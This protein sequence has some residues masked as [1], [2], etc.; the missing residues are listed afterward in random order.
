MRRSAAIWIGIASTT[1]VTLGC[2]EPPLTLGPSENLGKSES[3]II[4]GYIDEGHPSVGLIQPSGCTA[5]LVGKRTALTAAHCI[6]SSGQRITFC[7]DGHCMDGTAYRHPGFTDDDLDD[8]DVA[9]VRLD[10]N[11]YAAFGTVP[12]RLS[13]SQPIEDS[14]VVPVGF[15]CTVWDT[16]TG[17]GTKR[18]GYAQIKDVDS[19]NIQWDYQSRICQGDSGGPTFNNLTDCQIGVHS[20]RQGCFLCGGDDVDMRVDVY[21]SWMRSASADSSLLACGETICGD[22]IC[23]PGEVG[24]DCTPPPP[25]GYQGCFTDNTNRA[26]PAFQGEGYSIQACRNTCASQGYAYA[27]S[28]WYSQCF[29]GNSLGYSHVSDAECNTLCSSGGGYCGGAWR[30]SIYATG[31]TPPPGGMQAN[32]AVRGCSNWSWWDPV[33][34]PNAAS[35]SNYCVQNGANACEWNSGNGDCYVEFASGGCHVASGFPGWHAAVY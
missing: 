35:C 20:H 9:V 32:S 3:P 12:T 5:T 4:N 16:S 28:Q 34:K 15:G 27:G 7:T 31:V 2:A 1:V 17:Y 22:G 23:H 10:G 24:C 26:L 14:W 29:C 18:Y 19:T 30:N 11:F 6:T 25:S 21:Q 13:W 8:S 33:H